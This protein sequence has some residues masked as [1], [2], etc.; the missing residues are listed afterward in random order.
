MQQ[1]H[2]RLLRAALLTIAVL[3][4]SAGAHLGGGGRLPHPGAVA[5][6]AAPIMLGITIVARRK[7][8]L[9]TLVSVLGA[10][11]FVL[12]HAFGFLATTADCVPHSGHA[13]HDLLPSCTA[14]PA[15]A[16]QIGFEGGLDPAMFAAHAA[17]TLAMAL[18]IT[19]GETALGALAGWLRPL[20]AVLK[21]F[22]IHPRLRL[23][24]DAQLCRP[25]A[26]PFLI[27]P[28]LRGPPSFR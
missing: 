9:P 21:A 4:L 10:G 22:A 8:G 17:A 16:H 25:H 6:L 28:P 7:L 18:L 15:G 1:R 14:G 26:V 24:V 3:V 23:R 13:G 27:C 2:T 5:G 20:F 12:H 11:Q 19:H